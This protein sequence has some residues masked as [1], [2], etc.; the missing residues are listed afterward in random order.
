MSLRDRA[1]SLRKS[2]D[3]PCQARDMR[4]LQ[5]V[6]LRRAAKLLAENWT[7]LSPTAREELSR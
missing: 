4:S 6:L 3:G 5:P 1:C 2:L 7:V